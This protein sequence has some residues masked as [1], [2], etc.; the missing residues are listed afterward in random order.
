MHVNY[1]LHSKQTQRH[2][3]CPN[4][5]SFVTYI[6][7]LNHKYRVEKRENKN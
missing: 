4:K 6:K 7:I 2:N 3:K 5:S 1:K